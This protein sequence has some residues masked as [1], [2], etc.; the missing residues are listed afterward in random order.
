MNRLVAAAAV[1][2]M[3][4]GAAPAAEVTLLNVSY[5][6]TRELWRDISAKFTRLYEKEKGV[7]VTIKQSH[8]GSSTVR[9]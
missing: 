1:S 9:I 4:A 3:L 6:P 8:A 5:D 2:A 7:K